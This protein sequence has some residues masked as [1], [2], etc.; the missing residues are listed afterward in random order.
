MPHRRKSAAGTKAKFDWSEARVIPADGTPVPILRSNVHVGKAVV[1]GI[2]SVL[3]PNAA[4]AVTTEKGAT[5]AAKP[6]A[7][8][9]A[10]APKAPGRRLLD[11]GWGMSAGPTAAQ[12]DV[13]GQI[14]QA[15]N[16]NES[17]A[18]VANSARLREYLLLL[19]LGLYTCS[20][21]LHVLPSLCLWLCYD[22]ALMSSAG[23]LAAAG[24][25]SP[26]LCCL[27]CHMFACKLPG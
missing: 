26:W 12:D 19:G 18:A 8:A 15:V 20:I 27:C 6:A 10:A 1:H 16:G 5:P 23:P 9:P 17:T 13:S 25:A 7:A 11:W 14:E 21:E 22:S 4:P 24:M 3:L 2:G